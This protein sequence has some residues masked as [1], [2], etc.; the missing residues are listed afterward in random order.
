MTKPI[1][2]G[3]WR[4]ALPYHVACTPK[5]TADELD[6]DIARAIFRHERADALRSD[7]QTLVCARCGTDIFVP[8]GR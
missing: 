6:A 4:D 1:V 5:P 8:G 2:Y 7:G 3:Y